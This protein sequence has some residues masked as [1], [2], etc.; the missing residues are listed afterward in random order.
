MHGLWKVLTKPRDDGLAWEMVT[1]WRTGQWIP[2]VVV[3][4]FEKAWKAHPRMVLDALNGTSI[5]VRSWMYARQYL[6]T[7]GDVPMTEY[8]LNGVLSRDR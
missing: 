5:K 2:V 4:D 6:N 8:V 1:E 7:P 3:S